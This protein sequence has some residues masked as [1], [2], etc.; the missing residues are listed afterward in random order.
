MYH[1]CWVWA[2]YTFTCDVTLATVTKQGVGMQWLHGDPT[3]RANILRC[4]GHMVRRS[5][6]KKGCSPNLNSVSI[7]FTICAHPSTSPCCQV[8]GA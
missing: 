5:N 6:P 3:S 7:S 1:P 4:R 2:V 8:S